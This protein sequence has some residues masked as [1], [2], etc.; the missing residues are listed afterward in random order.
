MWQCW[1]KQWQQRGYISSQYGPWLNQSC[2]G[3]CKYALGVAS[4]TQPGTTFGMTQTKLHLLW[5]ILVND[6]GF[7]WGILAQ[8]MGLSFERTV[9]WRSHFG[10]VP[11]NRIKITSR[12]DSGDTRAVCSHTLTREVT[13][14]RHWTTETPSREAK[15]TGPAS[16]IEGRRENDRRRS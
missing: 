3:S 4:G 11:V 14:E 7:S 15:A 6:T 8:T 2:A 5:L 12:H 10:L 9:C 16:T 13:P 1:D